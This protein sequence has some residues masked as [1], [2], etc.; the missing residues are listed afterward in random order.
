MGRLASP[1]KRPPRQAAG[2]PTCCN[3]PLLLNRGRRRHTDWMALPQ[4]F[5]VAR[6][7]RTDEV[8]ELLL[9]GA[10]P[11]ERCDPAGDHGAFLSSVTAL[12]AAAASP[13]SNAATVAA[14]LEGGADPRA[15]SA[16]GVTALWYASGGGTGYPD[17]GDLD[18]YHPYRDWGGGDVDRLR[19]LLDAGLDASEVADNGRTALGEACTV[20]DPARV[21][22]LIE[23][24]ASVWPAKVTR[25]AHGLPSPVPKI[26]ESMPEFQQ[27]PSG[28]EPSL[29][30]LFLAAQ[31]GSLEC[32]RLVLSQGFPAD[33]ACGRENAL[34]HAKTDEIA[35]LFFGLGLQRVDDRLARDP[36]D[37]AF[38][39]NRLSA[40]MAMIRQI[41]DPAERQAVLQQ[42]LINCSGL[43]MNPSAVRLLIAEGADVN[44]P[45][46]D[47]GSALHWSCWQGDGNGGRENSDVE[48][49]LRVLL[50]AGAD[51]NAEARGGTRC[52]RR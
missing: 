33:F 28:Y 50:D 21:A 51:P 23:R 4:L 18:E 7:G 19:L 17:T 5:V 34:N 31:S 32:V 44:F 16:G 29:V 37:D 35:E 14:V 6:E 1:R 3:R 38:E 39:A 36:I 8:R 30:P 24:G 2:G 47:L 20:G 25:F 10:D 48:E 52:M 46:K 49:T 15:V 43:C 13:R 27:D 45:D 11:D 40:A 26:L 22:L 12:M 41:A 9:A 42:K